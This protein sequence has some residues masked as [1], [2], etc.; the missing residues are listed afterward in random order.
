MDVSFNIITELILWCKITKYT[1][2]MSL[3]DLKGCVTD[4][5]NY[6]SLSDESIQK[7][8]E[9]FQFVS[10]KYMEMLKHVTI[11]WV[12]LCATVENSS[13]SLSQ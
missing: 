9:I 1:L 2:N 4:N 10:L 5:F 12:L 6:S 7:L 13:F 3:F 11:G 8:Q